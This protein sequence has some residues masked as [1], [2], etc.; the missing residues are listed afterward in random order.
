MNLYT[1]VATKPALP[2]PSAASHEPHLYTYVSST[3]RN[4]NQGSNFSNVAHHCH[5]SPQ[6]V[7]QPQPYYAPQPAAPPAPAPA[8]APTKTEQYTHYH[9][10]GNTRAQVDAENV[11]IAHYTGATK[12]TQLVPHNPSASQ[13]WWCRELDGT[14]TLRNTNDIMENLQPGFWQYAQPGGYPYFI[15]QEKT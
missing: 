14:Y 3:K 11:S 6:Y 15:R 8:P 13:Q 9:W 1:Y 7:Q 12:P 10:Y 2:Q 4:H 5:L